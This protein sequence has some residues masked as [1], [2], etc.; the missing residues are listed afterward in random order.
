VSGQA[1]HTAVSNVA[2]NLSDYGLRQ[3]E[4]PPDGR[5][6]DAGMDAERLPNEARD[7][8][9]ALTAMRRSI[10]AKLPALNPETC[11]PRSYSGG[12][13]GLTRAGRARSILISGQA[14]PAC[15]KPT[16]RLRHGRRERYY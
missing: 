16:K 15:S 2:V 8:A 9:E 1:V 14:S 7:A 3:I 4:G 13:S 12:A 5:R 10:E 11:L 6:Q